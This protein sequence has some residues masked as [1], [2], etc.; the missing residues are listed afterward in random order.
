MHDTN[1]GFKI[2]HSISSKVRNEAVEEVI[3]TFQY[4]QFIPAFNEADLILVSFYFH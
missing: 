4:F 3:Y 2:S 1:V